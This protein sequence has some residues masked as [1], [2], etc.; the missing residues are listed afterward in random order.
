[1]HRHEPL[2]KAVLLSAE[3]RR[4]GGLRGPVTGGTWTLKD[5]GD[6]DPE[7][8][9]LPPVDQVCSY[10]KTTT[11]P[12]ADPRCRSG[13]GPSSGSF[14][15]RAL[16]PDWSASSLSGAPV[17]FPGIWCGPCRLLWVTSLEMHSGSETCDAK[18]NRIWT[19][20]SR[21][22]LHRQVSR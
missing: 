7:G 18:R 6:L 17:P 16:P 9:G 15:G 19:A 13:S 2:S 3:R 20:S 1:M 4:P 8:R 12:G 21:V 14:A 11:E 5:W 22:L 10:G